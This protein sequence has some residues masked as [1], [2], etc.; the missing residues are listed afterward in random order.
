MIAADSRVKGEF[1]VAPIYNFGVDAFSRRYTVSFCR[2]MWGLGVPADLTAFLAGYVR[3][4]AAAEL[5]SAGAGSDGTYLGKSSGPM[6][7]I[8][9]RGNIAG[10]DPSKE[11]DPAYIT[12]ALKL[13]FDVEIDVWHDPEAGTWHLGHDEPQYPIAYEF[14]LTDG[15]WVHCKNSEALRVLAA[16]EHVHCFFHDR[17]D[18]TLTSRGVIWAYPDQKLLGERCVAVMY[19][20]PE[21]LLGETLAGICHDN[22]GEL[23]DAYLR[24]RAAGAAGE[25]S[26]ASAGAGEEEAASAASAATATEP[27]AVRLIIFDLDGVLVESRDLHYEAL[28]RALTEVAGP[29]FAISRDEHESV[30]DG[31]ST[32][33]KLRLL[34]ASKGLAEHLNH[35]I[36][37]RKQ[38]LTEEL[39]RT[40]LRPTQHVLDA[41]VALKA[42]G[43]PIAVASNCIRSSVRSILEA[44]GIAPHIDVYVSNEDVAQPKPDPDMYLSVCRAFCVDPSEAL[45]IEDSPKGFEAAA[46]AGCHLMRVHSPADLSIAAVRDRIA[47]VESIQET[48]TV[49]VPMA[50]PAPEMWASG[51][52][53]GVAEAP[54][55]L[56]DTAGK[57]IIQW[58]MSAV[59]SRR[60][61]L[62]YVFIVKHSV[63]KSFNVASLCAAAVDYAPLRIEGIQTDTLG[64]VRTIMSIS[65]AA[66]PRDSPLVVTDGHHIAEWGVGHSFDTLLS[67]HA[68]GAIAVHR[69]ADP[70]W[71]YVRHV[72]GQP[73]TVAEVRTDRDPV[74]SHACTGL[75]Y[76][77]RAGD[78]FSAAES[79][80]A[81]GARERGLYYTASTFNE[82]ISRGRRVVT[83]PVERMW[84]LRTPSE[85]RSFSLHYVPFVSEAATTRI[86]D[87][88]TARQSRN[89]DEKGT[90][91]DPHL[92]DE[93]DERLCL[94]AYTLCDGLNFEPTAALESLRADLRRILGDGHCHYEPLEGPDVHGAGGGARGGLSATFHWTFM[95]LIGFSVFGT[96][97]PTPGSEYFEAVEVCLRRYL[98]R[99]M[100]HFSRVVIT[101]GSVILLGYPSADVNTARCHMRTM[102]K[103]AGLPLFE[104][105]VNDIVHMTL[106]RFAEPVSR[107]QMDAIRTRAL[108]VQCVPLGSL[109]VNNITVSPAT[110]KM[111]PG[112]LGAFQS[113]R[114]AF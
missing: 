95:Q 97:V 70:R 5:G 36:W 22:V 73:V 16:D 59:R 103:R 90:S 104:P 26:G 82:L 33:Q 41:V 21:E 94:A 51:I 42:M 19:S 93:P 49:V 17:D 109:A 99:F 7:F 65:D 61:S 114:V 69:S 105:Y 62:R 12:A 48:V 67:T 24:M 66:I 38:E 31:L 110:W 86:Y 87:E 9:H 55:G 113:H 106:V 34:T 108:E 60:F 47:A 4:R 102:L 45:V 83:V 63:L 25:G 15:L 64:A 43:F 88:M 50:G 1:Y 58:A 111:Q 76:Y 40:I 20:K 77:R 53:G 98:A 71:S 68:D 44:I 81:R 46:R 56:V 10:A 84:S 74:S 107:E 23:R 35:A 57:S 27:R 101:P 100:I 37:T 75:Y 13:G 29:E 89:I 112:E 91:H 28:N 92:A 39:V 79:L 18:Y 11:N 14:L 54:V 72:P 80:V 2:K 6:C 8:A 85:A 3:P 30:Y 96:S 52:S 78:F 32:N